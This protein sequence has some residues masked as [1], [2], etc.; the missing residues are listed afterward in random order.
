MTLR[1]ALDGG[2]R[3]ALQ[4]L[5]QVVRPVDV[6]GRTEVVAR[7]EQRLALPQALVRDPVPQRPRD[8][9]WMPASA[10]VARGDQRS[11]ALARALSTRSTASGAR[12]GPS[13][14]TTTGSVH[15]GPERGEPAAERRPGPALPV[16]T[17]DGALELVGA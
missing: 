16:R 10:A 13:A 17:V 2:G 6:A 4:A 5:R 3:L 7:D 15:V 9:E 12:S 1:L 14:S 11:A 8:D